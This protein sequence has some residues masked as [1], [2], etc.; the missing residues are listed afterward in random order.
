MS[1]FPTLIDVAASVC[2]DALDLIR[3]DKRFDFPV[4]DLETIHS[5]WAGLGYYSRA[6][7]LFAG[8]KKCVEKYDGVLP[9]SASEMAETIDGIGP[10]SAGVS[11]FLKRQTNDTHCMT[12]YCQH[13]I[14]GEC[15]RRRRQHTSGYF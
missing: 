7:R 14:W 13:R 4:K 11:P 6:T 15:T 9:L 8:A 5:F 10:Y 12:G 2:V 3:L 1:R